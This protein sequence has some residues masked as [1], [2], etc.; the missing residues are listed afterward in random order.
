MLAAWFSIS[1]N[2]IVAVS[3]SGRN[4]ILKNVF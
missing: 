2:N 1:R 3:G 4:L